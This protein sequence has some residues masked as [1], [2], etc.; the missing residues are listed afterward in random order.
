MKLFENERIRLRAP[1][2]EDLEMLYRWENDASSWESG[3]TY[4][5]YSRYALKQYIAES[6][7][8]LYERRQLRLMIEL[9]ETS[10]AVG[11]IDL[12]D[13]EPRHLRAETGI[14]LDGA[15]RRQGIAAEALTIM[16]RYAFSFLKIR[17]LYAHI[18][19]TNTP[20]L[21]LFERCGFEM[22][23]ILKEWLATSEGYTNVVI[24]SLI[25]RKA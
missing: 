10:A 6:G 21:R 8:D 16:I 1:E 12:Y 18:P 3:N 5:P 7:N 11:I 24:V 23:G 13:F 20:C 2:P 15:Y 14:L 9:K 19:Q 25:N 22:A 4:S 17:Q